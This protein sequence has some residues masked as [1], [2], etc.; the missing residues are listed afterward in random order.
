MDSSNGG[1]VVQPEV[2]YS[3]NKAALAHQSPC[4]M[5]LL[6]EVVNYETL[7]HLCFDKYG[8]YVLQYILTFGRPS[9]LGKVRETVSKHLVEFCCHKFA[10]NITE[11]TIDCLSANGNSEALEKMADQIMRQDGKLLS[12]TTDSFGNYIIQKMM[13][14]LP[15][16]PLTRMMDLLYVNLRRIERSPYGKHIVYLLKE[17]GYMKPEVVD[18]AIGKVGDLQPHN[19]K[20]KENAAQ[21]ADH[22][23]GQIMSKSREVHNKAKAIGIKGGHHGRNGTSNAAGYQLQGAA[24]SHRY[25]AGGQH[26]LY[27][28]TPGGHL[29][30]AGHFGGHF[31]GGQNGSAAKSCSPNSRFFDHQQSYAASDQQPVHQQDHNSYNINREQHVGTFGGGYNHYNHDYNHYNSTTT[32]GVLGYNHTSHEQQEYHDVDPNDYYHHGFNTTRDEDL[33]NS[34]LAGG[35]PGYPHHAGSDYNHAAP[36]GCR[37]SVPRG[38]SSS[39]HRQHHQSTYDRAGS[40]CSSYGAGAAP[41]PVP[42]F[43]EQRGAANIAN[44]AGTSRAGDMYSALNPHRTAKGGP[45][46]K[47]KCGGGYSLMHMQ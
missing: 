1:V 44:T 45:R 24:T 11:K 29:G 38:P 36:T 22:A 8:N 20:D 37:T 3:C 2:D 13:Q 35:S 27:Q 28:R 26:Q 4:M 47:Q 43:L 12:I 42:S 23:Q 34:R 41:P 5:L 6:D 33:G 10:S 30:N 31:G 7:Y 39:P 9:D 21:H 15:Q 14:V 40:S 25:Q 17:G 16:M 18:K 46:G 19:I 32:G